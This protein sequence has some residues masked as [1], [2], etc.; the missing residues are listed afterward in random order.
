M[1]IGTEYGFNR[2]QEASCS[3]LLAGCTDYVAIRQ[4]RPRH[5]PSGTGWIAHL[6]GVSGGPSCIRRAQVMRPKASK[7]VRLVD[8]CA[9]AMSLLGIAFAAIAACTPVTHAQVTTGPLAALAG[10]TVLCAAVI[11][12]GGL[13]PLF[14][15]LVRRPGERLRAIL[16]YMAGVLFF[17]ASFLATDRWVT[18]QLPSRHNIANADVLHAAAAS[19]RRRPGTRPKDY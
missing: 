1:L 7:A 11:A 14:Y 15:I 9:I 16:A 4:R 19:H 12:F 13:L 17:A 3:K 5:R 10:I 18:R 6:S 2:K 8:L